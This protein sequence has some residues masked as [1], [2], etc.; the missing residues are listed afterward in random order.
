MFRGSVKG[1]GYPLHSP[2]SLSLPIP[3]VTVC[4]LISTGV[5]HR[6]QLVQQCNPFVTVFSNLDDTL[7]QGYQIALWGGTGFSGATRPHNATG[8]RTHATKS[9]TRYKQHK[10]F[11][12]YSN[13]IH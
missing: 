11:H 12:E 10:Y 3:C 7:H 1:T 6:Q 9:S 13:N 8:D 2:V 4:H 5:Y